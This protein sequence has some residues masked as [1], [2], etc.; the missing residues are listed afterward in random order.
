MQAE[1]VSQELKQHP[2]GLTFVNNLF[3]LESTRAEESHYSSQPK[4][5]VYKQ[6]FFLF[7]RP[8]CQQPAL[9]Y[10]AEICATFKNH[11]FTNEPAH[12]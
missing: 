4:N 7:T 2:E 11:L 9:I 10:S 6:C 5:S 8:W 12:A 3:I 1:S